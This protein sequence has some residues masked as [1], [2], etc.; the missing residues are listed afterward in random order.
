[1]TLP[2]L[3]L[4]LLAAF[5]HASWNLFAKARRDGGVRMAVRGT[6]SVLYLPVHGRADRRDPGRSAWQRSCSSS[7]AAR[8]TRATPR[9]CS[10]ATTRR[11]V[12]RVSARARHRPDDSTL[13]AIAI[14]TSIRRRSH[15]RE[16]GLILR[17]RVRRRTRPTSG[18]E[19][20]QPTR[21]YRLRRRDRCADRG[22][23]AVGQARRDDPS[24][25]P[26][27]FAGLGRQRGQGDTAHAGRAPRQGESA[28]RSGN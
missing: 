14:R 22:L 19:G 27:L 21:R 18:D 1:M 25:I 4:V 9:C 15:S 12:A 16:H 2:I 7:A 10:A 24:P 13:A 23:H 20:G 11:P 26:P 8:C 17:R 5:A 3:G 28:E 6:S